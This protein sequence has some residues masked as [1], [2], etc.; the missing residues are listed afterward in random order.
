MPKT[1]N[2]WL[3][4]DVLD[5]DAMALLVLGHMIHHS[6][7]AVCR[8]DAPE[9]AKAIGVSVYTVYKALRMLRDE[10]IV[11]VGVRRHGEAKYDVN[12]APLLD[13]AVA[14]KAITKDEALD[15][16]TDYTLP[17]IA[18]PARPPKELPRGR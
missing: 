14:V 9:I 1:M 5:L 13:K 8:D 2:K 10:K 16:Y 3:R 11:V 18:V 15:I 12:I 7:C 17:R 4:A 6:S